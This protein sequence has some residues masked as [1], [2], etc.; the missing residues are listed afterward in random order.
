MLERYIV[1]IE[2]FKTVQQIFYLKYLVDY[3]KI[4]LEYLLMHIKA[5]NINIKNN[6]NI[7]DR[8]N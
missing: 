2:F 5:L 7:F 6:S 1:C 4:L 3:W 8:T